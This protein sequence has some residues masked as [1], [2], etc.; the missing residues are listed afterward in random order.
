MKGTLEWINQRRDICFVASRGK[1]YLVEI[2][3]IGKNS[4]IQPYDTVYFEKDA[5]GGAFKLLCQER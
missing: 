2:P 5:N 4:K 3:D 1:H